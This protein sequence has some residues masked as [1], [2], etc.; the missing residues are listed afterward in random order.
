VGEVRARFREFAASLIDVGISL[1]TDGS[2]RIDEDEDSVVGVAV[3]SPELQLALKHR[4]PPGT[5]VFS[6]EA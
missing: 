1:F 6:A 2:R 5:S 3:F 4:L